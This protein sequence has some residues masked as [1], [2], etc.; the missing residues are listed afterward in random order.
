[1][2]EEYIAINFYLPLHVKGKERRKDGIKK[3]Y[4][5]QKRTLVAWIH[6]FWARTS[7]DDGTENLPI[8]SVTICLAMA[9]K[10][11]T[12]F[13]KIKKSQGI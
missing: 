4:M 2:K 8:F 10:I 7:V 11:N 12:A 3:L 5:T 9:Y 6:V 13:K 1:M